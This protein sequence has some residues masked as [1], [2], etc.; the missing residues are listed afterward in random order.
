MT[1]FIISGQIWYTDARRTPQKRKSWGICGFECCIYLR[2]HLLA[3]R[4]FIGSCESCR[5][6]EDYGTAPNIWEFFIYLLTDNLDIFRL[7]GGHCPASL[8]STAR[9]SPE[10]LTI[11]A[12]IVAPAT[13]GADLKPIVW[14]DRI[15]PAG[16]CMALGTTSAPTGVVIEAGNRAHCEASGAVAARGGRKSPRLK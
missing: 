10:R 2:V 6:A 5:G 14:F 7:P 9:A 1:G 3:S 4:A 8:I 15:S 11:Y 12:I 13:T 16:S